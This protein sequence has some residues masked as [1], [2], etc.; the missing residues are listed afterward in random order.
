MEILRGTSQG[1]LFRAARVGANE[2]CQLP[3]ENDGYQHEGCEKSS[4][5][6]RSFVPRP[7]PYRAQLPPKSTFSTRLLTIFLF[8]I[9]KIMMFG[10]GYVYLYAQTQASFALLFCA[11]SP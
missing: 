6:K 10:F 8:C 1:G 9:V 4:I 7:S 3:R 2:I 5:Y 11:F